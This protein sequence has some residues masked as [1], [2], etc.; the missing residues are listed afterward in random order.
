MIFGRVL[1]SLVVYIVLS[2]R[3]TANPD[4]TACKLG[5]KLKKNSE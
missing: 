2:L 5:F 4:H 1:E 3:S